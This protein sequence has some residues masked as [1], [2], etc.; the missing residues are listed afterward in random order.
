[1]RQKKIFLHELPNTEIVNSGTIL[2]SPLESFPLIVA[3]SSNQILFVSLPQANSGYGTV[4]GVVETV[5]RACLPLPLADYSL[6]GRALLHKLEYRYSTHNEYLTFAFK[7]RL[8]L[9]DFPF[10]FYCL[11]RYSPS[12][13]SQKKVNLEEKVQ[14]ILFFQIDRGKTASAARN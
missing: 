4:R 8:Y 14:F 3:V 10:K 12:R 1:M 7:C 6:T 5:M 9:L 2:D 13:P 11:N